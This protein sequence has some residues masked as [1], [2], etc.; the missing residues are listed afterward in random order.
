LRHRVTDF[1]GMKEES[2][3]ACE[4]VRRLAANLWAC[5]GAGQLA[6]AT[7]ARR[8]GARSE[9]SRATFPS[10]HTRW[11]TGDGLPRWG[12]ARTIGHFDPSR[13]SRVHCT[14]SGSAPIGAFSC[15][16]RA[17]RQREIRSWLDAPIDQKRRRRSG[18]GFARGPPRAADP[19]T[20]V[21]SVPGVAAIFDDP[22]AAS[23]P[24]PAM[25]I[26][27]CAGAGAEAIRAI[28]S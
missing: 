27:S 13:S 17:L 11:G 23:K 7:P 3:S 18:R 20:D 21:L 22:C 24:P 25:P 8:P 28:R 26:P 2:P 9:P 15:S 12:S 16:I 4:S 6:P 10:P 1:R 19:R 14:G 5:D